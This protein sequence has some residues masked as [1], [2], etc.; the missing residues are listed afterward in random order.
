MNSSYWLDRQNGK[1]YPALDHDEHVHTLIIGA[2]LSGLTTAYELSAHTKQIIVVEADQIGYGSSGRNTGKVTFQHG[3]IYHQIIKSHG[4]TAAKAYYEAQ[5]KALSA[6]AKRIDRHGIT[7]HKESKPACVY[8]KSFAG[9]KMIQAEYEAYQTLGIP[10]ELCEGEKAPLPGKVALTV[11][12]QFGFD[13]YAYL[14]GVAAVLDQMGIAVYEHSRAETI[15]KTGSG[16]QVMVNNHRVFAQNIVCATMTPLLDA[17]TFFYAKTYPSLSHLA[18]LEVD[19]SLPDIMLYGMDDPMTSY[20][21]LNDHQ[22]LCGGYEHLS[23]EMK[24]AD[25]DAWLNSLCTTWHTSRPKQVWDTQDLIAHDHLPLIGPLSP[26]YPNFYI[27]CGFSK[28]GNTQ[29]QAAA[30]I[31]TDA[32]MKHE[33]CR[34]ALFSPSRLNPLFP[35]QALKMNLR[36][37]KKLLTSQ[38]PPLA[39]FTIERGKAKQIELDQHHYGVYCDE[40]DEVYVVDIRCPHMGCICDFNAVDRTWD[41]PCH[42]SRFSYRGE[43]IKGPAQ[44]ALN[45]DDHRVDPH[46]FVAKESLR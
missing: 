22:L 29:S 27:A 8:A 5:V 2:G 42:G 30:E 35:K 46:E 21:V 40:Q 6:I 33:N 17:F 15:V 32:I 41:C 23:G 39:D 1:H 19:H 45:V 24:Q 31:I 44:V 7:C 38:F 43:I 12:D 9:I 16:W 25:Q 34:S 18:L 11:Y 20:H 10:G 26:R 14:L 13:P 37:I 28:W 3:C 36:S 4:I